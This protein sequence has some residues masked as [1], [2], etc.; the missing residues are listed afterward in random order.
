[1]EVTTLL[2]DPATICL[3]KFIPTE[4]SLTLIVSTKRSGAIC[5]RCQTTSTRVHSRYHRTV[6]DLPWHGIS[7]K[8]EL[9]TRRFFCPNGLCQQSIFCERLPSV[10]ARY[11]RKTARLTSALEL[12]GFALG[13]EAGARLA[14]DLGMLTSPDTLLVHIRR[15]VLPQ[16]MTPHVLGVDDWAKRK[17]HTYGTILVDLE[18]RRVI[19][20]LPDRETKTLAVWLKAQ[21]G[22]AVISRDRASAYADA[23]R[24]GAPQAVQV[25]DRFHLLLNLDQAMRRL[26]VRKN[27]LLNQASLK[28][29]P[30]GSLQ[31][32]DECSEQQQ[33]AVS[34]SMS[35]LERSSA[36][37][38]EKR[39]QLYLRVKELASTGVTKNWIAQKLG[40][41]WLTVQKFAEA[42]SFP[43]RARRQS[44]KSPIDPYLPFLR[45]RWAED[46]HDVKELMQ[47]AA[48]RGYT[49]T[50]RP[51]HRVVAMWRTEL[52]RSRGCKDKPLPKYAR[53][54]KA[55]TSEV[56]AVAA[57]GVEPGDEVQPLSTISPRRAAWLLQ[58]RA[59][60]LKDE[61]MD[62]VAKLCDLS[63][64]IKGARQLALSFI[65]LVRER[66]AEG[67]DEWLKE[68]ERSGV[69]EMK[70]YAKGLRHD[71]AAVKAGLSLQWSQG[72]VEGQVN[73]LKML[74]RQ[75]YGR[76]KFDLL[77][78]RVLGRAA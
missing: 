5:P 37:S 25:A 18:R 49:G 15:A 2:A 23:A 63:D 34:Q 62:Y 76:A 72:Q 61:E 13:G 58:Q 10:V 3:E 38:R 78:A 28:Q 47:E 29:S 39:Y 9:R 64:E 51:L 44:D 74:K 21:T 24:Q 41:H 36:A 66:K 42:E 53:V 26:L 69:P 27:R 60:K 20:L 43:E 40:V 16:A 8:L 65:A 4:K 7:V 12:I 59:D 54:S 71:Y 56:I 70:A 50:L 31:S 46:C 35:Q 32:N 1:M 11:A 17:G 73:R 14:R 33:E 6:A 67:F 48:A 30:T 68:A 75:M 19:D 77:R 45:K 57:Y 22:L 52:E 55:L